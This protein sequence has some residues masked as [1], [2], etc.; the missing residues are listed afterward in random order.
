MGREGGRVEAEGGG[1]GGEGGVGG[2]GGCRVEVR[3]VKEGRE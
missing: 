3:Q 1:P 2:E